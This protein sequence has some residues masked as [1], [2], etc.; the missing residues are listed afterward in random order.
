[1]GLSGLPFEEQIVFLEAFFASQ[2]ERIRAFVREWHGG[3]MWPF[4]MVH[5][6]IT[7]DGCEMSP[8]KGPRFKCQSC[9]DIDLCGHCFQKK[10]SVLDGFHAD[11]DFRLI[12]W[13]EDSFRGWQGMKGAGKVGKMAFKGMCGKGG[14]KGCGKG[15]CK[16]GF[17][18]MGTP[19]PRAC[20]GGC[21]LQAT[22]HPTHC[23]VACVLGSGKHGRYC[24][25]K[26]FPTDAEATANV[27]PSPAQVTSAPAPEALAPADWAQAKVAPFDAAPADAAQALQ[28]APLEPEA[29]PVSAVA[30]QTAPSEPAAPEQPEPSREP[31]P[32]PLAVC[33]V[34]LGDGAQVQMRWFVGED[35][36]EVAAR[37]VHEHGLPMDEI[38][39]IAAVVSAFH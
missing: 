19:G 5:H 23:C 29:P 22:W 39:D 14:G 28:A 11:H 1:L 9:D 3:A 36:L 13:P 32:A 18:G 17:K 24:E 35:P 20:A 12:V 2:I 21:G 15:K 30:G 38:H 8:V 34:V 37:F 4:V 33:P 25:Q 7:C 6:G 27:V 26:P 10:C 16:G 31:S